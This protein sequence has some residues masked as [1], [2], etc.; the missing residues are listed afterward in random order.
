VR[1]GVAASAVR[2]EAERVVLEAG[3]EVEARV[4]VAADGL[5]S[6]LR[7]EL[8][9]DVPTAG[10]RR[11]GLRRH[12]RSVDAPDFVEVHWTEGL[13]AYLTP[14]G[15]GRMGVAFLFDAREGEKPDFDAFLDRVPAVRA[16]LQGGEFDSE[17]R[18]AGPLARRARSVVQGR[19]VL[20]GDAA[21]Y[22]DAITGEGLTLAF[23][24]A[25]ALAKALPAAIAR[26]GGGASLQDYALVHRRLFRRYALTA[27]GLL[28]L[29][30]RPALR[31]WVVRMLS[32]HPVLFTGALRVVA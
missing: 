9:L 5:A 26:D 32:R 30:R 8:G 19:V 29:S 14:V 17:L 13:E 7:H 20:L 25:R 28:W 4:L 1:R 18:G 2:V 11:F 31:R 21:G 10:A 12:Y 6:P 16:R 24:S 27:G 23:A 3:E 15:A 22:V